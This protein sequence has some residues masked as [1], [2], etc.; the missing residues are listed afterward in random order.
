MLNPSLFLR[1]V[2][3]ID[4]IAVEAIIFLSADISRNRLGE[5]L[6]FHW[7]FPLKIITQKLK[8]G[9]PQKVIW[10]PVILSVAWPR[11]GVRGQLPL[12]L[13]KLE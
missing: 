11:E 6:T 10:S 5:G 13:K 7:K 1:S 8:T 12:P 4:Y 9:V 2:L 3:F